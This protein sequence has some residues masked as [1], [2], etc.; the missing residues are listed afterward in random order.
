MTEKLLLE[1]RVSLSD[2]AGEQRVSAPTAWRWCL[3]GVKGHVLESFSV[4][5]RRYT[6]REAFVRWLCQINGEQVEV[7][8]TI[9]QRERVIAAAER[10][11]DRLS[12]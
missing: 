6:T 10:E 2:L 7:T 3:R 12:I 5:G 4:G 9:Q 11:V 8:E 1:A